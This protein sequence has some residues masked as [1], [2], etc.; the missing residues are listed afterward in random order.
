MNLIILSEKF[1]RDE[2]DSKVF[3]FIFYLES[4]AN[5]QNF[6]ELNIIKIEL[7]KYGKLNQSSVKR[8]FT[9]LSQKLLQSFF[10]G[11]GIS[12]RYCQ[13]TFSFV[14]LHSCQAP[15]YRGIRGKCPQFFCVPQIFLC[16]EKLF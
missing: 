11:R 7:R 5:K 15:S 14:Q 13:V 2:S 8:Y 12:F 6:S 10:S 1:Q 9:F 4:A 3:M 16:P